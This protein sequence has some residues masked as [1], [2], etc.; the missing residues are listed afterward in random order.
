MDIIIAI[1]HALN[2]K[3]RRGIDKAICHSVLAVTMDGRQVL[4][5]FLFLN[6]RFFEIE[7]YL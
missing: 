3:R 5:A 6:L 2:A 7:Q 1:G 4:A